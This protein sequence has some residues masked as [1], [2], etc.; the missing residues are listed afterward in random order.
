MNVLVVNTADS[1]GGAERIALA[2]LDGY[3]R[4]GHFTSLA[5]G[6]KKRSDSRIYC[7]RDAV[8]SVPGIP[9]QLVTRSVKYI[10]RRL[11]HEDFIFP[12]TKKLLE[13]APALMDLIHC[14]NLHG[15]YFDLRQLSSLSR[16][17]PVVITMHDAWLLSGHCAHSFACE[18]WKTGCGEC[19]DL[20]IYP[21]ISH[22]STA[23]NWRR[24]ARIFSDSKFHVATPCQW[25]MDKVG[26][27]ILSRGVLTTRVIPNG[28]DLSIFKPGN[29][30]RARQNLGLPENIPI[31]LS[32]GNHFRQNSFKDFLSLYAALAKVGPVGEGGKGIA[33]ILG[34]QGA[35]LQVGSFEIR[36]VPFQTSD[37][38]VA[39]YFR[40]A[41]LYVHAAK[42]ETSPLSTLEACACGISVIAS[43]VGGVPEQIDHGRTGFLANPGDPDDLAE[44]IAK[45]LSDEEMR[46]SMGEAA[47]ELAQK[48]F[49]VDRMTRDYLAWFDEI[50]QGVDMSDVA[51]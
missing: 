50:L 36:F 1:G 33:V 48:K 29:R 45:L 30:T 26:Q 20:D 14:H 47:A 24:K 8:T 22:D 43:A 28:V 3:E 25:L 39:D 2:C 23:Y 16:R 37:A 13:R 27:S 4:F 12:E 44:K 51:A 9:R 31:I 17:I 10:R 21:A 5:V 40:A 32:V 7:T 19:P 11:G 46:K 35:P 49:G 34:D 38:A 41:N 6:D 15:G 42:A 18:R